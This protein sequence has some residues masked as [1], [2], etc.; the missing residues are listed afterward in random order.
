M[1]KEFFMGEE[2]RNEFLQRLETK[3]DE[4]VRILFDILDRYAN[5]VECYMLGRDVKSDLCDYEGEYDWMDDDGMYYGT[6]EDGELEFAPFTGVWDEDG[7][8]GQYVTYDKYLPAIVEE[9]E[10]KTGR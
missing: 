8:T 5:C 2:E 4:E 9:F 7:Y 6:Y 10:E 3:N 1:T